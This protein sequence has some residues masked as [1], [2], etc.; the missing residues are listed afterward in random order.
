GPVTASVAG[1]LSAALMI[2]NA[3]VNLKVLNNIFANGFVGKAGS[4]SYAVYASAASSFATIDNNNYDTSGAGSFARVGFKGSDA[5]NIAAWRAL[6]TKDQSSVAVPSL[7]TSNTN[8][9]INSGSTPTPLESGALVLTNVTGDHNND[10]RPKITPTTYGGNTAPDMGAYEFDG[11]PTDLVPPVITYTPIAKLSPSTSGETLQAA[12]TDATGVSITFGTAPRIYYKKKRDANVIVGN[13]SADNGW[14]YA[15][16]TNSSSPFSF[17]INYSI[18]NGGT[19]SHAD[20]ILYFVTAQDLAAVPNTAANPSAGFAAS[21]VAAISG[22]PTN[23]NFYIV[24][25]AGPMNGSYSIG[26]SV[27]NSYQTIT[28]ALTDLAT[29]G[30]SGP[31]VFDLNDAAYSS[32]EAFP[33]TIQEII[34]SS[35]TNTVTIKPAPGVNTI[36]SGSNSQAILKIADK[37]QYFTLDGSNNGT[38]SRNLL[39]NNTATAVSSVIWFEG[40]SGSVGVKNTMV[41]NTKIKGG[42]QT[43]T[44]GVLVAGPTVALASTGT[45]HDNISLIANNIYNC[46]AAIVSNGTSS[47]SK[48]NNL[49]VANNDIGTDTTNMYNRQYGVYIKNTNRAVISKN[50]IFNVRTTGSINVSG[51]ELLEGTTNSMISSNV[52]TGIYSTSTSG[53]GAYGISIN[54]SIDISN[55]SICNNMVSDIITSNYSATGTTYNAFGIRLIGGSGLKVYHNSVNLYGQPTGGTSASGSAALLIM[56]G[57][58]PNIDIRNNIFTNSMRGTVTGSKHYAY[59][60]TASAPFTSQVF[61]Y[62]NFFVSA[63]HGILMRGNTTDI[64]TL[65]DLK[66]ATSANTN[67]RNDSVAYVAPADLHLAAF[68]NGNVALAGTPVATIGFDIDN[69][70]R[71][72]SY[73]YMGAHE[74]SIP[75]PVKLI[76]FKALLNNEDV[77]LKW[78]TAS[79]TNNEGF[80]IE[81]SE[82]NTSFSGIGFVKGF[83]N[84]KVMRNYHYADAGAFAGK[85]INTLYY[86]LVQTDQ[87]GAKTISAVESVTKE[88]LQGHVLEVYPNPFTTKVTVHILNGT[89]GTH[90]IEVTDMQGRV[91]IAQP[92]QSSGS[93]TL[94]LKH[95]DAGVYFLKLN[96]SENKVMKLVKTN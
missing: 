38:G 54:S 45:G 29:R 57:T 69:N 43:N 8:L 31:V 1:T 37:V 95:L 81:R 53:Y 66:S 15:D 40:L 89:S 48:V 25:S 32:A 52:V 11:A 9:Q 36:I 87:N 19:V 93:F 49:T 10:T 20:T 23:P 33:L 35:V 83:G 96:G 3:S 56:T 86:R 78:S 55:D 30:V 64:A 80:V 94:D 50:K 13:T 62:N 77:L 68:S 60:T 59:W 24:S 47:S 42:S 7:F 21:G 4:K 79:E 73:P 41:K 67:S 75:V 2:R 92:V 5:L 51:I 76:S 84:S 12:I 46:N 65:A 63:P 91:V 88:T 74:A 71:S 22:L 28:A 85:G 27:S 18:L 44:I 82:D 72:A 17:Y 61:N 34:G 39:L 14:K 16:A 58:Y 90:S 6:T 26:S 70:A